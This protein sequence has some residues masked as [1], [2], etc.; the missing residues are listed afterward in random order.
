MAA[1]KTAVI[2][3][4]RIAYLLIGYA[5]HPIHSG[6][7]SHAIQRDAFGHSRIATLIAVPHNSD[8]ESMRWPCGV[9]D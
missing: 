8:K 3:A 6:H 5:A 4:F 2:I 7:L 9:L 1:A